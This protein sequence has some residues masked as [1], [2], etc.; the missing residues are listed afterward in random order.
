MDGKNSSGFSLIEL[1]IV[2]GIISMVSAILMLTINPLQIMFRARDSDRVTDIGTINNAIQNYMTIKKQTICEGVGQCNVDFELNGSDPVSQVL[3]N[4]QV[5]KTIPEPPKDA[6]S[7]KCDYH[8][9]LLNNDDDYLLRWCFESWTKADV[10]RLVGDEAHFCT[11][12]Q[13]DNIAI[14]FANKKYSIPA[15]KYN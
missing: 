9:F 7:E 14:C 4:S 5:L 8:I 10:D 3:V 12:D 11:W 1:M 13:T 6:L 15:I 2:V